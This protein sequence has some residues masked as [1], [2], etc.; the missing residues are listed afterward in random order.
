MGVAAEAVGK[1]VPESDTELG[2][3]LHQAEKRIAAITV[4]IAV[5]AA[6]DLALDDL[7]ADAALRAASAPRDLRAVKHHQRFGL[8][9]V[10]PRQQTIEQS[11]AGAAGEDA[12]E[13]GSHLGAA[14][15]IRVEPIRL[16]V[17]VNRQISARI[18]PEMGRP[19]SSPCVT[20]RRS[21]MQA[22]AAR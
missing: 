10:Q 21:P 16:E 17:G 3:G 22:T 13:P 5:S 4:G 11:E 7:V 18:T 14:A 20:V 2:A 1:I 6:A 12:I 19:T 8:V 9:G 15:A